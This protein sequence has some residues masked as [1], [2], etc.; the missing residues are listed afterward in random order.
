MDLKN[1]AVFIPENS[2]RE[3]LI[4]LRF[5]DSLFKLIST[6]IYEST[7]QLGIVFLIQTGSGFDF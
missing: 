2:R 3:S 5:A 6:L 4:A 7:G 1:L